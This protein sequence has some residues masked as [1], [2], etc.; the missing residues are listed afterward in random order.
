MADIAL[1]P[2]PPQP[3]PPPPSPS[4]APAPE[5]P[6]GIRAMMDEIAAGAK[7]EPKSAAPAPPKE[8]PKVAAEPAKPDE[9]PKPAAEPEPVGEGLW[10]TAPKHLKNDHYK[11]KRELES[12]LSEFERK[13]KELEAKAAPSQADIAKIKANEER[14]AQL[15]K[16]LDDR[17]S[18]LVQADYSKSEDFK[19]NYIEKGSKAYAKAIGEVKSLKVKAIDPATQEEAERP[20]TQADFDMLRKLDP[21]EQDKKLDEM[22]GSSAKRVAWHLKQLET[23]ETEA[24][25]AIAS[26]REKSAASQKESEARKLKDSSDFKS[27]RQAAAGELVQ[28]YG[29]YFAPDETNPDAS[30]ALEEGFK[31]VDN[32]EKLNGEANPKVRAETAAMIRGLAAV[33][34]R[35]M[36]EK[37]QMLEKIKGLEDELGKYRR[38]SPGSIAPSGAAAPAAQQEEGIAAIVKAAKAVSK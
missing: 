2:A 36:V 38:S 30:K 24:N 31:Y 34:P 7:A 16:E 8:A 10:R 6:S 12:K 4:P 14:I 21:Y 32:A 33:A 27:F 23:I 28:K 1:T 29:H 26:A 37:R 5:P 17:E 18:R 25:D 35:L 19:K 13:N 22:F 20:A 9:P 11:T 15:E 3:T